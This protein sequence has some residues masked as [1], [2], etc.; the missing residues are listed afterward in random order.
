PDEGERLAV[1]EDGTSAWNQWRALPLHLRPTAIVGANDVVALGVMEAAQQEGVSIPGDLSII[2]FDNNPGALLAGLTT[3]ERPTET[4]G[5]TVAQVTLEQL[6]RGPNAAT[7][8]LRLR[9]VLIERRSV[10]P[11]PME[12]G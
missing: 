12:G 11:P 1:G 8:S 3:L 10:G 4:L 9:P 5:E 6:A 2:G 7:V